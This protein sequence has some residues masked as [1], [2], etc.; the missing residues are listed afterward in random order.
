M[1]NSH[2][3]LKAQT[4]RSWDQGLGAQGA[5]QSSGTRVPGALSREVEDRT[6]NSLDGSF[7]K[8]H[9]APSPPHP[10]SPSN[11]GQS[12]E[13]R[14]F[15]LSHKPSKNYRVWSCQVL[16]KLRAKKLPQTWQEGS[17]SDRLAG[18][19][20]SLPTK[21]HIPHKPPVSLFLGYPKELLGHRFKE[22]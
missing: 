13:D 12:G 22:A 7:H 18:W 11:W 21:I 4:R 16:G 17:C 5:P 20:S 3:T 15:T 19:Y 9:Q 1:I 8:Q 6:V 2:K 10:H 14:S